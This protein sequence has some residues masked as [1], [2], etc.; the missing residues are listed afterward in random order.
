MPFC[1]E[2]TAHFVRT[3]RSLCD[4]D[5]RFVVL[6][7]PVRNYLHMTRAISASI[8]GFSNFYVSAA[9]N[10]R[11]R[12]YVFWSSVRPLSVRL[13]PISR[14][15]ISLYLVDGFQW[16]LPQIFITWVGI[17]GKVSK[18]RGQR[19]GLHWGQIHLQRRHAF[20]RSFM[21]Y[22]VGTEHIDTQTDRNTDR[23]TDRQAHGCNT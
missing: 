19:S 9:N 10:N 22:S 2:V 16:N 14:D 7:K 17:A 12:H 1:F 4:F 13:T 15:A 21:C 8:L 11:R 6:S 18:A 23:Q 3:L 5:L 20:R